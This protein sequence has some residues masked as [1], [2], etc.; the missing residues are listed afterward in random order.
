MPS[1]TAATALHVEKLMSLS[2]GE[3]EKSIAA[4][5][6]GAVEIVDGVASL[7]EGGGSVAIAFDALPP[8]RLGGLLLLPQAR[9]TL[10]VSGLD[11][12]A[13]VAF[14][15]RFELAFQRGGG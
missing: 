3:F 6:G 13:A 9:V 7:S 1:P 15:Q 4:L 10:H 12:P 2:R 8:K 14:L 5:A 11:E